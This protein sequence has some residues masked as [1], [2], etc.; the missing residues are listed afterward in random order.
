MGYLWMGCGAL[1]GALIFFWQDSSTAFW[2]SLVLYGFGNGP[3]VGYCYDLNNRLTEATEQGMSIVMFGLNFGASIV[4]YGATLL[5]DDTS[6]SYEVMPVLLTISMLCVLPFLYM[7]RPINDI[8][9]IA[10]QVADV[11]K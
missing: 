5:W 11:R 8:Q 9:A 10:N 7:T 4:P 6:M 3:C 1:G 2:A